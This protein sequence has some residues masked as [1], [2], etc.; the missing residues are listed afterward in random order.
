MLQPQQETKVVVSWY[1]FRMWILVIAI[2]GA[3]HYTNYTHEQ[4][5]IIAREFPYRLQTRTVE[6]LSAQH[7]DSLGD[8]PWIQKAALQL[9][10]RNVPL[11]HTSWYVIPR[12]SV[13]PGLPP[14]LVLQATNAG[15]RRPAGTRLVIVIITI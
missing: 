13:L 5:L 9:Y 10:R 1:R 8:V 15:A 6:R 4:K 2:L 12:Y 11:L 7:P 3:I 14:T